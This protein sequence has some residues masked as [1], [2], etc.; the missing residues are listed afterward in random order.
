MTPPSSISTTNLPF[1]LFRRGKV[2]DVYDIGAYLLFVTTDRVSAFDYILPD[3]IPGKG[4]LLNAISEFWFKKTRRIIPNHM[5]TATLA[6]FPQE[7][8]PFSN[9]LEGRSMVVVKTNPIDIECVV[10]QYLAGSAWAEYQSTGC[11]AGIQ[12]PPGLSLGERLPEPLFTPAIKNHAGHDENISF[13][14]LIEI[15]GLETAT[16]LKNASL[17][18]FN[19]AQEWVNSHGLILA[20]TKFEFGWLN[21]TLLLIDEVLTPDSSRYWDQSTY[22]VGESPPSFDKQ[23]IRDYLKTVWKDP[24]PIPSLPNEIIEKVIG[25][26]REGYLRITGADT[27]P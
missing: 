14:K 26:Y 25:K 23:I 8:L 22:V 10:R 20:D 2:R 5:L 21:N 18:L 27:L 11:V 6:D 13:E 3:P 15:E 24:E 19:A 1:P 16:R 17:E 4:H 9:E 12:L 7:L